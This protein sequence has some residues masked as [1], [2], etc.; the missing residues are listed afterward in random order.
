M[1]KIKVE[2]KNDGKKLITFLQSK[3]NKL[4]QSSIFKALRNK[5]IR[6]NDLKITD[7][8][9][10]NAGDEITLYIKDE[11]L[12]GLNTNIELEKKDVI[13]NDEN[14]IIVNKKQGLSVISEGKDIGLTE[15]VASFL[16]IDVDKIFPCHRID[17]NTTGLVIFAKSKEA[18]E[19]M[20]NMFK[21]RYVKKYYKCL[22]YGHPKS[23]RAELKAF[24][25]KDSKKST[26]II[27]DYKKKGYVDIITRYNVLQANKDGTSLL[28][29][30]LVTGRTH[31]IRAHL[32]YAG[33]PII[34]DG[35]YGINEINK[36]FGLKYQE[37]ESYKIVFENAY[38]MLEYLKGKTIMLK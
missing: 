21:S 19:I 11:V 5:D 16:R 15:I 29:V 28:E 10:L 23:K 4:P 36:S 6:I 37:L 33:Y 9:P 31:Q 30:E 32:A 13:Y 25:F 3:F 14:I 8:V 35:K 18:E 1:I 34:G 22:V 17:R 12:F 27:S 24:L 7:N 38:G 20:L 2:T 26:V